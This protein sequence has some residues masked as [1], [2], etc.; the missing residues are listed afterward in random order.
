MNKKNI[1]ILMGGIAGN[2]L[3]WFDFSVYGFFAVTIGKNFFP[4]EDPV[5]QVI[6]AFGIFAIGFL[7]RPV[8][9]ILLGYIGDRYGRQKAMLISVAA[10]AISTFLVGVLPTYATIG[11]AAPL[12]LLLFRMIQGL[13]VGGEYTTSIVYMVEHG[14]PK[15]RGLI[16]SFATIGAVVGILLGSAFGSVL[17]ASMSAQDL[18]EWGWRIP[19][20][21]GLL[22]GIAGFFLRRGPDT[23]KP[24]S[25]VTH[26]PLKMALGQHKRVMAQVAGMSLMSAIVFYL[27]FV[28]MVTWLETVDRILPS[29]ALEINTISMLVLLPIMLGAGALSDRVS[30]RKIMLVAAALTAIFAWPLLWLMNTQNLL[31][32]ALGQI[33]FAILVGTYLG[34]LPAYMVQSIAPAVRCT[35]AGLS[36]NITLGIAGGCTPILATW[37]VSTLNDDLSPAFMVIAAAIIS[38]YSL[39]TM[40][41]HNPII[42]EK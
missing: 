8:G 18:Q 1:K 39:W 41:D 38:F 22:L 17:A 29:L 36:Y 10:M 11:I 37:M 27:I 13:S 5:A 16:G 20:L 42:I 28:Y 25:K 24:I 34:V 4:K 40:R 12:L 33:G 35:A 21:C 6:A 9:G 15:H 2:L 30:P 31:H 19:F 3:E 23:D 7:M 14:S 26:N 32:M